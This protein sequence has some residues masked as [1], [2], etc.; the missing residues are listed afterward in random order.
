MQIILAQVIS[1]ERFQQ[2]LDAVSD[3]TST[4]KE[5]KKA[6]IKWMQEDIGREE[7]DTIEVSRFKSA[8]LNGSVA[9]ACHE[10]LNCKKK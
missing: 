5:H 9:R 3:L 10:F 7:S 8:K 1:E 4:P 2:A 6:F